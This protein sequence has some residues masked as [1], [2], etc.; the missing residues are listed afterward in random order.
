MRP[1]GFEVGG[2]PEEIPAIGE[3]SVPAEIEGAVINGPRLGALEVQDGV[4]L[5]AFQ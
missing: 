3:I 1:N 4:E 2:V 5:P